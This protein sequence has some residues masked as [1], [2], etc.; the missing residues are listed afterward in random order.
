[1][2]LT[3]TRETLLKPLQV[4]SGVVER[5][6]TLPILSNVFMSVSNN[7]LRLITTDL[8]VELLTETA[9]INAEDGEVTVAARKLMDI[10]RALPEGTTL[11]ISENNGK[12]QL[13]AGKSRFSLSTLPVDDFPR[14]QKLNENSSISV[15]G[16]VLKKI[17]DKTYF[18]MA[19]QDVRYYLNGVLFEIDSNRL[20]AVATDGHRLS[21]CDGV[22]K[23]TVSSLVQAIIPRKGVLELQRLLPDSDGEVILTISENHMRAEFSGIVYTTKLV[24]GK[25]PDYD[26]VIPQNTTKKVVAERS[27]LKDALHRASI[28]SNEKYRGVRLKVSSNGLIAS[29]SN[30]E[31]EE[32]EEHISVD[33][34]GDDLEIGFNVTYI[35]DALAAISSNE[36]ELLFTDGNSSCL[37]QPRDT[38]DCRH[39]I[40]PMRL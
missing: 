9:L 36:I 24:D 35:I 34:N 25:F 10:C 16:S 26:R 17:I 19:Q 22:I 33:Y 14:I 32:A 23:S 21:V 30:P 31:L 11:D 15:M 29:T 3:L 28:L 39:V 12:V 4:V 18:A 1:M 37:I 7:T 38:K 40:M 2:K 13:K 8:E 20:R 6:Q 27:I 5:R